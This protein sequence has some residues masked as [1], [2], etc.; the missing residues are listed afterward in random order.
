MK[1]FTSIGKKS[2]FAILLVSTLVTTLFTIISFAMDYNNEMDSLSQNLTLIESTSSDPLTKA[3]WD[4]NDEQVKNLL[5]GITKVDNFIKAEIYSPDKTKIL[6][7]SQIENYN[8]LASKS[9]VSHEYSLI[10]HNDNKDE[11]IGILKVI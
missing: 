6:Y 9:I 10:R 4:F 5:N 8:Q 7:A 2:L 11:I 1:K 3:I